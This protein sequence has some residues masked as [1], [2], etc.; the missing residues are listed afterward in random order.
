MILTQISL[1]DVKYMMAQPFHVE[2]IHGCQGH[3][4]LSEDGSVLN[5]GGDLVNDEATAE[6]LTKLAY[7]VSK[8]QISADKR[9]TFKKV[10]VV[11]DNFMYVITVSNH[12]IYIIKRQFT[13]HEPVT[14]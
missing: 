11:W 8:V 3:L 4:V 12:K 1:F 9:E 7:L 2:R 10:S 14:A 6:K 13:P 5:S